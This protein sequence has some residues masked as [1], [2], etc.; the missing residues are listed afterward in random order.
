[1]KFNKSRSSAQKS[2]LVMTILLGV[3]ISTGF[4]GSVQAGE[5]SKP[6]AAQTRSVYLVKY[7]LGKDVR[8]SKNP[9]RNVVKISASEYMNSNPYVCTPSGFGRK[10]R[11]RA[12]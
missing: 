7:W 11:C 12:I 8:Y 2:G 3:T 10:A 5:I 9:S 6:K 1:M 4:S